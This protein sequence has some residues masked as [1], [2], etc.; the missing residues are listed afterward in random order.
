MAAITSGFK[1]GAMAKLWTEL[2]QQTRLVKETYDC[3]LKGVVEKFSKYQVA[4]RL[5]MHN[6]LFQG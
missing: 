4:I 2:E 3:L 6:T 1:C 5:E